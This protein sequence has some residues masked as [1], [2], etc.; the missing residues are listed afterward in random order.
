MFPNKHATTPEQ[1]R[2]ERLDR[3]ARQGLTSLERLH[4]GAYAGSTKA[5]APKPVEHRNPHLLAMAENMPC[6][7]Q[8]AGVCTN[9][10]ST[11]VAA[12]SNFSIH[13]KAGARK[14]NDEYSAWCCFACHVW[15]DQ[16]GAPAVAKERVFMAAHARQVVA[17]RGI[18]LHDPFEQDRRAAL[19]ALQLLNASPMGCQP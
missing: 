12:H 9:D 2:Q 14:A 11:T 6:L 19:W 5:A 16:G 15:F 18:A 3:I 4:K 8:I 13:G 10:R 7:F 1:R 17:W